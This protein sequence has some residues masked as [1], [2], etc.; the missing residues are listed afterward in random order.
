M[1]VNTLALLLLLVPS[2][3]AFAGSKPANQQQLTEEPQDAELLEFIAEFEPLDG[4]WVDPIQL[5]TIFAEN[6]NGKE[7]D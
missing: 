3:F 2:P 5:N 7:N 4:Q 1:R 6:R